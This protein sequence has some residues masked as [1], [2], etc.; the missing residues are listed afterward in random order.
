MPGQSL[1]IVRSSRW[2]WWLVRAVPLAVAFALADWLS[3]LTTQA[4]SSVAGIWF[5]GGIAL[6]GLLIGGIDLWP[7]VLIGGSVT[8]PIWN[9]FDWTSIPVVATNVGAAVIVTLLVRRFRVHLALDRFADVFGFASAAVLGAIPM[10]ALALVMLGVAG[11]LHP[12]HVD[13]AVALWMLSSITGYIVVGGAIVVLF[14]YRRRRPSLRG[15]VEALLLLVAITALA[16][17]VFARGD[18][19]L[20]IALIAVAAVTAGRLGP[21]GAA[22]AAIIMFAFAA[23]SVLSGDGPFGGASVM[24]RSLAYQMVVLT[25]SVGMQ[26]IGALGSGHP[27]AAPSVPGR[28]AGVV[29]LAA[30]GVLLGLGQAV[31]SISLLPEIDPPAIAFAALLIALVV[32]AG[33]IAGTGPRRHLTELRF[34]GRP[35]W[36]AGVVSGLALVAGEE[37][38]LNA[39]SRIE[40]TSAVALASL[41][42]VVLLLLGSIG[43]RGMPPPGALISVS[44]AVVAVVALIAGG[45]HQRG[46]D[47]A[48]VFLAL[49][50]SVCV[51]V[52]LM[53]LS[54]C[55]A[56]T[57]AAPVMSV[58][59]SVAAAGALLLCLVQ[60]S[61]PGM[62]AFSDEALVGG[63]FYLAIAGIL[64]PSLVSTW[65]VPLLGAQ[66]TAMFEIIAPVVAVLAGRLW[67]GTQVAPLEY[68]G[69]ATIIIA[70]VVSAR[71]HT[72]EHRHHHAVFR[73]HADRSASG[74]PSSDAPTRAMR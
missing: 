24:Q 47:I 61:L 49:G 34:V 60:G 33:V 11:K 58:V 22:V 46:F 23:G 56:R 4:G 38:Y 69:I 72:P 9:G 42:P 39:A 31:V 35:W 71:M 41:A 54:F 40:V 64:L 3:F 48:A 36:I 57:S 5:P 29:L 17:Q 67:L 14:A 55:R 15:L 70:V 37:L 74:R 16:W 1:N 25:L 51:A 30:G 13:A 27:E 6:A 2:A 18:G 66:R 53:G 63:L 62:A 20:E 7:A 26:S 50:A 28:V 19:S 21:P 10:N 45:E 68:V 59:F 65:A 44:L 12:E 43:R 8:S 52:L 32:L 73:G